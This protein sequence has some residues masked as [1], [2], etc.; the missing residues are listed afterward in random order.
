MSKIPLLKTNYDQNYI[1]GHI[2]YTRLNFFITP[3]K[4][5]LLISISG[6][7][8]GIYFQIYCKLIGS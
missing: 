1:F 7:G 4:E 3:I 5:K 6:L 2:S 8:L